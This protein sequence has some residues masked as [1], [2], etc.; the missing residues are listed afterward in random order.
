MKLPT[1]RLRAVQQQE[2]PGARSAVQCPA[3]SAPN[4]KE[5]QQCRYCAAWLYETG[6][7]GSC[8]EVISTHSDHCVYCGVG[9][10]AVNPVPYAFAGDQRETW[11]LHGRDVVVVAVA[12]LAVLALLVAAITGHIGLITAVG[13]AFVISVY[14]GIAWLVRWNARFARDAGIEMSDWPPDAGGGG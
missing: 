3:C 10:S 14:V 1:S 12:V 11:R 6:K 8:G 13:V 4:L 5:L 2:R 9:F 7:C